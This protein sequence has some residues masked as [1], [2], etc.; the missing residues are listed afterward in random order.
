MTLSKT[1]PISFFIHDLH[2]GGAEKITVQLANALAERGY[3][4]DL[5]CKNFD[6]TYIENISSKVHAVAIGSCSPIGTVLFLYDYLKSIKPQVLYTILEKPSLLGIIAA[7]LARYRKVVPCVHTNLDSYISLDHKMRRRFLK[8]LVVLF[9]RYA[10]KIVVVS[11][12][13]AVV[14][15]RIFGSHPSIEVIYNGFDLKDLQRQA[16]EKI[17]SP[18]PEN[19]DIPVFIACGRMVP[20]KGFDSL[21]RAFA[22]VRKD[23]SARLIILGDGP[24]KENLMGLVRELKISDDVAFPGFV[25]TPM[26]WFARSK[27]FV[28]SSRT[29]GFGNVLVEA[30]ASGL[31]VVSTDCPSGP[32][33]ILKAGQYGQLVPVDDIDALAAAM[34]AALVPTDKDV[35]YRASARAYIENTYST[36]NMVNGY[37]R[38][39]KSLS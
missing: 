31:K 14:L 6:G 23:I 36:E 25:S 17:I 35:E 29:E 16:E 21:L 34:K 4:V 30:L 38:V 5:I 26:A 18:F 32:A 10:P 3:Q 15:R 37:I 33:E 9:Y 24:L 27:V 1:A 11:N 20:Q 7:F 13:A 28:L 19:K 39:V 2:S 12:S 8:T 22:Q